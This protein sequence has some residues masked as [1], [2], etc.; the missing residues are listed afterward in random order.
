MRI[1]ADL[2]ALLLD[3][4]TISMKKLKELSHSQG[5]PIDQTALF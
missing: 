2:S 4:P 5:N 1:T 3:F